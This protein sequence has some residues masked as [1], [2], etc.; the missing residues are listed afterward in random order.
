MQLLFTKEAEKNLKNLKEDKN[1]L[2]TLKAVYKTLGYLETNPRHQSL[3]THEFTS[4]S[5][6]F[7]EKVYEAYAQNNTPQ[8]YRIFFVYGPKQKEITVIAITPHP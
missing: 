7:G 6:Q 3:K 2:S 4:L 8:A 1:K 5:K